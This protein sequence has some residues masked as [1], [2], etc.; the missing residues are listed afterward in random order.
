MAPHSG[1]LGNSSP[2]SLPLRLAVSRTLQLPS[3]SPWRVFSRRSHVYLKTPQSSTASIA[4][5]KYSS[6]LAVSGGPSNNHTR[7]PSKSSVAP[8][9]CSPWTSVSPPRQNQ[10]YVPA[11]G[12]LLASRLHCHICHHLQAPRHTCMDYTPVIFRFSS[13]ETRC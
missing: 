13:L 3:R 4:A 8:R 6:E 9:R 1:C 2:A 12:H 7:A 5:P 10:H 11:P